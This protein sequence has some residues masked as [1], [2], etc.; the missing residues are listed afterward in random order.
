MSDSNT[1]DLRGEIAEL[2]KE[3][4]AVRECAYASLQ[5]CRILHES[6][7][8]VV[9][10]TNGNMANLLERLS[11]NQELMERDR[12]QQMVLRMQKDSDKG[13]TDSKINDVVRASQTIKAQ[14]DKL[15]LQVRQ[16]QKALYEETL[17][18]KG[19][20]EAVQMTNIRQASGRFGR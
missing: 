20:I 3:F 17:G 18:L 4:G 2:R 5:Q 16:I 10:D 14:V 13:R 7:D 15:E 6:L 1:N 9:D 19:M 12:K 8:K 11:V